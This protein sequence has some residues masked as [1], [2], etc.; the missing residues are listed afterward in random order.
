VDQNER[1]RAARLARYAADP[2]GTKRRQREQMAAWR[3]AHPGWDAEQKPHPPYYRAW[4]NATRR[5]GELVP[6]VL[7]LP[8]WTGPCFNCGKT[9]AEG[10][11]HVVPKARGGRNVVENLQP[12]CLPCNQSKGGYFALSMRT[13]IGIKAVDD[14]ATQE[15]AD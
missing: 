12:A 6:L 15:Q 3:A 2:E 14:P 4:V 13:T 8:I 5:F 10:V 11:D 7:W 9:P 1:D